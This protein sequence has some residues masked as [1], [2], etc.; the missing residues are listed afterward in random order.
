MTKKEMIRIISERTKNAW[1]WYMVTDEKGLDETTVKKA[2]AV[3]GTLYS[4]C[5]DLEILT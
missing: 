5:K 2:G 4:L 3:W 1:E